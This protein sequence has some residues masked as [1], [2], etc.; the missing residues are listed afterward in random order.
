MNAHQRRVVRR[1]VSR[2]LARYAASDELLVGFQ[3]QSRRKP[4]RRQTALERAVTLDVRARL[5]AWMR[6]TDDALVVV[7]SCRVGDRETLTCSIPLAMLAP[8]QASL[9][10]RPYV[11]DRT[12]SVVVRVRA[13]AKQCGPVIVQ[14]AAVLAPDRRRMDTI[15]VGAILGGLHPGATGDLAVSLPGGTSAMKAAGLVSDALFVGL[16]LNWAPLEPWDRRLSRYLQLYEGR[17]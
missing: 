17:A 15:V 11:L 1:A 2:T 13:H 8:S 14:M 5:D 7:D 12:E 4:R 10:D 16:S 3:A 6:W 9:F